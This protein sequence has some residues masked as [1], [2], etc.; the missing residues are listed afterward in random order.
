MK[1]NLLSIIVLAL[2][3]VNI[4]LTA[5][6]M[7]SVVGTNKKVGA[8]VTDIAT[9][10]QLDLTVPGQE[11]P[12]KEVSLAD[13]EIYAIGSTMTLALAPEMITNSKGEEQLKQGYFMCSLSFSIDKKHKDY[14]KYGT[15]EAMAGREALLKDAVGTVMS[16]HTSTELQEDAGLEN[17]KSELLKA[18]Q[19]LFQSDFIYKV[20][21][22]DVKYG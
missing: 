5:V 3:L 10:L 12:K 20:S 4:V 11:A 7:F 6:M 16:R 9:V 18:V 8:L 17:L 19:D 22:S 2:L 13:T 14:K 15:A 1:K 21:I